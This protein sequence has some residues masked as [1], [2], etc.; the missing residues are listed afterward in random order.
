MALAKQRNVLIA[1]FV[2]CSMLCSGCIS[3][4]DSLEPVPDGVDTTPLL[5]SELQAMLVEYQEK[6][7]EESE[8][9]QAMLD[10]LQDMAHERS[11]D[12]AAIDLA[13]GQYLT[14]MQLYIRM[15]LRPYYEAKVLLEHTT[16]SD[17][18]LLEIRKDTLPFSPGIGY[19]YGG[20]SLVGESFN[21]SIRFK[22]G[23]IIDEGLAGQDVREELIDAFES[24][25][26]TAERYLEAERGHVSYYLSEALVR[27]STYSDILIRD[28]IRIAS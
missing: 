16:P 10:S 6:Y 25:G 15:A 26:N 11:P 22:I 21:V 24:V 14:A 4:A 19:S 3:D 12:Y 5:A 18:G 2:V 28:S 27:Q 13:Y 7:T 17:D 23:Q 20:I 9:V 8:Q 1:L